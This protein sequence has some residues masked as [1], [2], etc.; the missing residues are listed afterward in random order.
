MPPALP[1][2]ELF[3]PGRRDLL[4][5]EPLPVAEAAFAEPLVTLDFAAGQIGEFL[6]GLACALQI[7]ADDPARAHLR[8]DLGGCCG[9]R[10]AGI[11]Q[12]YVHLTLQTATAVVLGLPVPP[13]QNRGGAHAPEV[14]RCSSP[15]SASSTPRASSGSSTAGQSFQSRARA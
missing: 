11:V 9:L 3:R 8:Q 2:A 10:V 12:R 5:R 15:S 13:E 1:H 4:M 7:G 6:C 14:G